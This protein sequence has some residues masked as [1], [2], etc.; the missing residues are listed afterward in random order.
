MR[1][2]KLWMEDTV[3]VI[4]FTEFLHIIPRFVPC[5]VCVALK[6]GCL[7][8]YHFDNLRIRHMQKQTESIILS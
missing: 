3:T 5:E 4:D 7:P 6:F 1:I 8:N 2:E